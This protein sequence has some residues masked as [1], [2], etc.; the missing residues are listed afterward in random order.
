LDALRSCL[1]EPDPIGAGERAL[2]VGDWPSAKDAFERAIA[3]AGESAEA[4]SGL[5]HAMLWLGDFKRAL[6]LRERAYLAFRERG[7]KV[8][9]ARLALWLAGE[10]GAMGNGA[11]ANGWVARAERLVTEIGECSERGWLLLRRSR[12]ATDAATAERIAG[13]AIDIAHALSDRDLEIAAISRRGRALLA[14]GR[15]EEGFTC[16]DEA[17]AAATS[18]EVR[19][20][21][22]V[23]DAY[24]DMIGAC[25]RTADM[26]RAMQWCR[27]AEEYAQRYRF[28][29]MFAFCRS[30]YA[31]VL[32]SLGRWEEAERELHEA[33]RSYRASFPSGS[34][35]ALTR[36][37][38]LRLLQ[39]RDAEA[40]ELLAEHSQNPACGKVVAMM[41][42]ARG[43]AA[44]AVR[45]LR[46]RIAATEGDVLVSAPLRALLVEAL[47]A[48]R[49]VAE[50]VRIADELGAI[51]AR[52]GR[53]ALSASAAL[54]FGVIACEKGDP[55]AVDRFEAATHAFL[56]IGMPLPAAR[57]RLSLARC[58]AESDPRAAREECRAAVV[59]FEGL[60]AK[61]DLD[62]AAELR[63][64]LGVGGRIGPR[65]T[66]KLT[67]R[68]DEVLGLLSLGLSNAQIG[69]RLFISPK[70]AEHHVAHI[71]E[72]LDL[73]TRAAAAAYGVRTRTE[74]PAVK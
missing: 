60:G 66:T 44:A 28:P 10:H 8:E 54:A 21:D 23:G 64:R 68:E 22:T 67:K 6:E 42:L 24:C 56:S 55:S 5:G 1:M 71:L 31:G 13:E 25:E 37:A 62:R 53:T 45:V 52:T 50:A 27:V 51:A 35:H 7:D 63:R 74:K 2:A 9:A 36:L 17:M 41:H 11:I 49:E 72:K 61:R 65:T 12:Q 30:S 46:K 47:V 15:I 34:L 18:G 48:N 59:A 20:I 70:T 38:E 32:V 19:S 16:L 26:D 69:R 57:A 33:L 14:A 43:D 58:L 73:R 39:G 4:L 3:A 40:E 29:P